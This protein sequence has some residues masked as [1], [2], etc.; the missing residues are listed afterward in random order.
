MHFIIICFISLLLLSSSLFDEIQYITELTLPNLW[1][2]YFHNHIYILFYIMSYYYHCLSCNVRTIVQ[3]TFTIYPFVCSYFIWFYY[4]LYIS[5]SSFHYA[6]NHLV[7]HL[8]I[9]FWSSVPWCFLS[10]DPFFNIHFYL[11]T[12]TLFQWL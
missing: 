11:G 3:T 2:Y 6:A 8:L 7:S 5:F 4:Y 9:V 1:W 10:V 12:P